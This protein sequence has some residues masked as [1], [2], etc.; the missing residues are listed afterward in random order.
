MHT[1][2]Y[3]SYDDSPDADN[4]IVHVYFLFCEFPEI[5]KNKPYKIIS[6]FT[7]TNWLN[8]YLGIWCTRLFST[9][10]MS[11]TVDL[12]PVVLSTLLSLQC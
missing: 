4:S 2:S 7:V 12:F 6:S 11:S 9:L 5:P 8:A 3:L 10:M 1:V